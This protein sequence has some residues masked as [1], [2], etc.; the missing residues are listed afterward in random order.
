MSQH[1]AAGPHPQSGNSPKTRRKD[2]LIRPLFAK[3]PFDVILTKWTIAELDAAYFELLDV[4][5]LVERKSKFTLAN[6]RVAYQS[7]RAYLL[8]RVG[9]EDPLG[10]RLK[11]VDGWMRWMT[12]R[13][14]TLSPHTDHTYF[15]NVRTFFAFLEKRTGLVSPF[16]NRKPPTLPDRV[17]KAKKPA[18]CN[19][20]LEA[21][22]NHPKWNG[23][24][25]ARNV[26]LFGMVLF[27][28]LRRSEL[29]HLKYTD[30][31]MQDGTVF[32]NKGKGRGGGK[33]RVIM[34]APDLRRIVSDYLKERRKANVTAPDFF[35]ARFKNGPISLSTLSRV[36]AEVERASGVTFSLHM[37]RHSFITQLLRS[38]VP[39]H[40]V[41]SL[42]GHTQIT[43]TAGYL[44]VWDEDKR[45]AVKRLR[46]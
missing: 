28:G 37:L 42:A 30:V 4:A 36:V 39:I 24:D 23:F 16:H 3:S 11:D 26:A 35:T 15:R 31:D 41:S 21:A 44:R 32:V 34:M 46:F 7:Y 22:F 12:N 33:D 10:D 29:I 8:T 45:D 18:E 14:K 43:T 5:E 40:T 25:R 19:R 6:Y 27:A 20:I 38:G 17:P 1:H 2:V 9:P 13:S